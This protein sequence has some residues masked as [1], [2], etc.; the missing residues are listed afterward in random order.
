MSRGRYYGHRPL[1]ESDKPG[2]PRDR[3]GSATA[4]RRNKRATQLTMTL[5]GGGSEE[6]RK[7]DIP[8]DD[9]LPF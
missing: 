2:V 1:K 6:Q 5:Y 9:D 3:A 8:F 7:A 4:K